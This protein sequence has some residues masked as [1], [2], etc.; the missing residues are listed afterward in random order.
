MDKRT[1]I[2]TQA[3]ELFRDKGL[4]FTMQDI[5]DELHI[6]K[7]TIYT[8]FQDKEDLLCAMLDEGFG[9][10]HEAKKEI[11]EKEDMGLIEKIKAVMIA[12]PSQY[13]VLDFRKLNELEDKYPFAYERLK[14]HLE[15]NWEPVFVLL[16][17]AEKQNLIRHVPHTLIRE[18]FTAS[19]ES[20]LSTDI[21]EK[22]G[23]SYYPALN[24]LMD[25]LMY[26]IRKDSYEENQ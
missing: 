2:I 24:E 22:E 11:M 21:L 3:I 14:K 23:I 15:E 17:E 6:A 10:I 8:M 12:M 19:I 25:I 13:Q 7:K 1:V 16:D 4:H 18:I 5:S 26:G 20:F 9:E